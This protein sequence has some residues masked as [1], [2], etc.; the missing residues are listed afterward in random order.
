MRL[1]SCQEW[2]SRVSTKMQPFLPPFV[3][4]WPGIYY[5]KKKKVAAGSPGT[6]GVCHR[7]LSQKM[8]LIFGRVMAVMRS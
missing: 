1:D 7:T 4:C 3:A 8:H 6:D 5:Q 2:E